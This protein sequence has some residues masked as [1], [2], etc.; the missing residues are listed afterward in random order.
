M[1]NPKIRDLVARLGWRFTTLDARRAGVAEGYLLAAH[2]RGEVNIERTVA[3]PVT[4]ELI[5][6]F[7]VLA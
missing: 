7:V 5:S 1:S 3:N 4:H 6:T 2:V